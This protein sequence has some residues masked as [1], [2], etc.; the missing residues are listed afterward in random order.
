MDKGI[1]G[2][3]ARKGVKYVSNNVEKDRTFNQ[4]VDRKTGYRTKRVLTYPIFHNSKV[5]G[6]IQSLNKRKD[7]TQYDIEMIRR[8]A[9]HTANILI[10]FYAEKK[11]K[12]SER[13]HRN[14]MDR[15]SNAIFTVDNEDRIRYVNTAFTR[16]TGYKPDAILKKSIRMLFIPSDLQN[17]FELGD[18]VKEIETQIISKD[19][20]LIPVAV[21][22]TRYQADNKQSGR[23]FSIIDLRDKLELEKQQVELEKM[24]ND[25][26]S[27][28]IHD[29]K[30]PL[31]III[32]FAELLE[33]NS[34]GELNEKQDEFVNKIIQSSEELLNL[35]NEVLEVSKYE[36]GKMPLKMSDVEIS[37]I[38]NEV[39]DSQ[40]L[41][42]K[43]K[44]IEFKEHDIEIEVFMGDPDKL[45]RLF[46]NLMSNALKFTPE[47]GRIECIYKVF[48]EEEQEYIDIEI[49]DNGVGI[50]KEDLP[51]IF[52]KYK[53]SEK[54]QKHTADKGTGLGLS[55]CKLISE[56]HDG[57]IR[58]E[59]EQGQGTS[60]I[61]TLPVNKP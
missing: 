48:T 22:I 36:A 59:S 34:L 46:T 15:L 38:I 24:R 28:I 1:C 5:I 8:I 21:T 33:S 6:V 13:L 27:M 18:K 54:N 12:E 43:N 56:A 17:L 4:G 19:F 53:Q 35:T 61:V 51:N 40:A 29:L 39:A 60:F 47:N 44:N 10:R 57:S 49:K 2:Y 9:D 41:G 42:F 3:V 50:P 25:F 45:K 23:I 32:G 26:T 52:S 16:L 30:N 58:A 37:T 55:I 7:Y 20:S 11:L 14:L 31:S